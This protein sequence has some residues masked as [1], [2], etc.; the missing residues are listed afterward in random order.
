MEGAHSREFGAHQQLSTRKSSL[1]T[2]FLKG[3]TPS[4]P[5]GSKRYWKYFTHFLMTQVSGSGHPPLKNVAVQFGQLRF[6]G[7]RSCDCFGAR[8]R[9]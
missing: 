3:F 8:F 7:L 6:R 2:I 5:H 1:M 4:L 9:V